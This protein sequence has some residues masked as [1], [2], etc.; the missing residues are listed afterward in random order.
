MINQFNKKGE[1]E[2][3]KKRKKKKGPMTDQQQKKN[4]IVQT[5]THAGNHTYTQKNTFEVR[6]GVYLCIPKNDNKFC[7]TMLWRHETKTL[8]DASTQFGKILYAVQLCSYLR[9]YCDVNKET[10]RYEYLGPNCCRIGNLVRL[11]LTHRI[12]FCRVGNTNTQ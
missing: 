12:N 3:G 6:F 1:H 10:I 7:I 4:A 5:Y 9:E 11:I 2:K 8:Q